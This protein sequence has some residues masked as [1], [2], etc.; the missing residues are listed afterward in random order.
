[1]SKQKSSNNGFTL[2]ELV[3]AM[4]ILAFLMTAVSSLMGTSVS[5]YKQTK[6]DTEL[7]ATAQETYNQ[8]SDSIMQASRI[9]V[10]GYPVSDLDFTENGADVSLSG[11]ALTY[12]M[13]GTQEEIDTYSPPNVV[14]YEDLS[15]NT[16]IA[17][18]QII[19]DNSVPLDVT[20]AG[21]SDALTEWSIPNA[22]EGGNTKV[23]RLD[24]ADDGSLILDT[25]DTVR[26]TYTFDGNEIYIER[27]YAFMTSKN[28]KAAVAATGES[29][30]ELR[31]RLKNNLYADSLAYLN[32]TDISDVALTGCIFKMNPDTAL[33]DMTI[34]YNDKNTTYTST[35]TVSPRN[36]YVFKE[37]AA[38]EAVGA[39]PAP[40]G[41]GTP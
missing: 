27:E 3:I 12:Y 14:K 40:G 22:L 23:K 17:V 9:I 37:K 36:T 11:S 38:V 19:V 21:Q 39:T 2:V 18:R 5:S 32:V 30:D 6:A 28:D 20:Q 41:P 8:I 1:M 16:E 24:V 7:Q 31:A 10:V 29:R 15:P 26:L 34:Y 4:A 25:N 33:V 35:G 13:I